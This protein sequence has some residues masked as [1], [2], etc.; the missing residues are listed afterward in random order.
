M[1]YF[2][3]SLIEFLDFA[4]LTLIM[5]EFWSATK[6]RQDESS[7]FSVKTVGPNEQRVNEVSLQLSLLHKLSPHNNVGGNFYTGSRADHR[8]GI[9]G[10]SE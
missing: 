3:A 6:N 7:E 9:L 8:H 1:R 5:R 2:I 10:F 4:P